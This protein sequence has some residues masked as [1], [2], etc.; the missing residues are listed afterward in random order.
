VSII[1]VVRDSGVSLE[2][3][4]GGK[5]KAVGLCPFHD[6]KTPSFFVD[7]DE[8]KRYKCFGCGATGDVFSFV[9]LANNNNVT[10]FGQ[11]VEHVLKY[12]CEPN[13]NPLLSSSGR[14]TNGALV[15]PSNRDMNSSNISHIRDATFNITTNT[16]VTNDEVEKKRKHRIQ[17]ANAAAALFYFQNLYKLPSAGGAR[18]HLIQTRGFSTC[19]IKQV[20]LGY[21]TS[22]SQSLV[23]HL[24]SLGFTPEEIVDSGLAKLIVTDNVNVSHNNTPT[25]SQS[26]TNSS[27]ME[28]TVHQQPKMSYQNLKDR[29][30]NR[31]IIPIWDSDG[32]HIVGFGGRLL[33]PFK[34][35][36]Y[37]Y[38]P[39]KY[40]NSPE[41]I[42]YKK[43][44]ILFGIPNAAQSAASS[45]VPFSDSDSNYTIHD[46]TTPSPC[47]LIIVEGY[48][49]AL[50]LHNIG[51]TNVAASMGT[52]ISLE[53][54]EVAAR[55]VGAGQY[56]KANATNTAAGRIILLLDQDEAGIN[57]IER[58]CSTTHILHQITSPIPDNSSTVMDSSVEVLVASL[59]TG[60]KDPDE[61]IQDKR[62]LYNQ[63]VKSTLELKATTSSASLGTNNRTTNSHNDQDEEAKHLKQ[64][65]E[66]E[67]LNNAQDWKLWYLK[68]I[69]F[70]SSSVNNTESSS[71][72]SICDQA[73]DFI[74]TFS[75]PST[76][77]LL[78]ELFTCHLMNN[79]SDAMNISSDTH[80]RRKSMESDLFE[81]IHLKIKAR[82]FS[83]NRRALFNLSPANPPAFLPKEKQSYN[84]GKI[85]PSF[86]RTKSEE[87]RISLLR[88]RGPIF[89]KSTIRQERRDVR[90]T[91]DQHSS[92]GQKKEKIPLVPH[93]DG[94]QFENESDELWLNGDS[95]TS[96]KKSGNYLI[97][98]GSKQQGSWRDEW[99]Y[100]EELRT[101]APVYFNSNAF[102]GYESHN[103]IERNA[104]SIL[105][106][107]SVQE[108][109]DV[110][111]LMAE[112]KMLRT[113]IQYPPA[114]KAMKMAMENLGNGANATSDIMEWSSFERKW[115]FYKLVGISND[116]QEAVPPELLDG[117]TPAQLLDF[118]SGCKS[119]P[120]DAFSTN[121]SSYGRSYA[122][123]L[124]AKEHKKVIEAPMKIAF[125]EEEPNALESVALSNDSFG[126]YSSTNLAIAPHQKNQ[127]NGETQDLSSPWSIRIPG[128]EY[129]DIEDI[130][131]NNPDDQ[132]S[133]ERSSANLKPRGSLD[134]FFYPAKDDVFS[135]PFFSNS[136]RSLHHANLADLI[137]QETVATILRA[138][139]FKKLAI[140]KDAW[141][142]AK[143]ALLERTSAKDGGV[144]NN[145]IS[146]RN[147]AI[148]EYYY[149]L[150]IEE[151]KAEVASIELR[152][153]ESVKAA[154]ELDTAARR[155]G[156]QMLD[157]SSTSSLGLASIMSEDT[158][159][160]ILDEYVDGLPEDAPSDIVGDDDDA[161]IIGYGGQKI[162]DKSG[163]FKNDIN[164]FSSIEIV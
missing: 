130:L 43:R 128:E 80:E 150:E 40:L 162:L 15:P 112:E 89:Q 75:L 63:N 147:D 114:R 108:N 124:A 95:S 121:D 94:F 11:A 57:A 50:A 93:F 25:L 99:T 125:T 18:Q 6:E 52:A 92:N 4:P 59:P 155:I 105:T 7:N 78:V 61:F 36:N 109:P 137:V 22:E 151:L 12:Y 132:Q 142:Q 24:K 10:T 51:V 3:I 67:A 8:I 17:V 102:L 143:T 156:S 5:Q 82:E 45:V 34:T 120:K 149:T 33:L 13:F 79:T 138:T 159:A 118:L 31:I 152:L 77:K 27:T 110:Q 101:K 76:R 111:L 20:C 81:R 49:D 47:S 87:K 97:L 16:K 73:S 107:E 158:L 23:Q 35:N 135:D 26:N 30:V 84:A 74:S 41:T 160:K 69:I 141:Q 116:G 53:Q 133:Q 9:L 85:N 44:N 148:I 146:R 144:V 56:R 100:E 113:L 14:I 104:E 96:S 145:D 103:K 153:K 1:D 98:G 163:D 140:V 54:L 64:I 2:I 46:T 134:V 21:A 88:E 90:R 65:F 48:M 29:F 119:A 117:G 72:V 19:L 136:T 68:Q 139:A 55:V 83:N 91:I 164:V 37:N 106:V 126:N 38:N 154:Q 86:D 157:Y 122:A 58:L 60:Y 32:T 39:P 129:L 131:L 62:L 66:N 71:I 161:Y 123:M 42:V 115:L 127:L 28:N 70:K